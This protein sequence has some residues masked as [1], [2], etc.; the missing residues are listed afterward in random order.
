MRSLSSRTRGASMSGIAGIFHRDGRPASREAILSMSAAIAHRGRDAHGVACD[1]PIAMAH[2]SMRSTPESLAERQPVLRDAPA[3]WLVADARIDNRDE[4]L[5]LLRVRDA[6]AVSDADLI[7][8]AFER[9]GRGCVERIVGDFAFARWD[10]EA[11]ELFCARDAMGVKPFYFFESSGTFAFASEMKALLALPEISREIDPVQVALFVEGTI[12]DRRRTLFRAIQRL[13]AAHEIRIVRRGTSVSRFWRPDTVRELTLSSPGEYAEAFSSIFGEAVRSRMRSAHP[14]GAALSGG[15]D[16]SSIVCTAR[17][18]RLAEGGPPIDTFSLVFPGLPEKELKLID[19]RRYID[20]VIRGGGVTPTFVRGDQLSPAADID[21]ILDK[22]DAPYPAPNLYLHWSMYRAARDV[23]VKV[24]LD[25]F[26]GDSAVSHGFARLNGLLH[27]GDWTTFEREVRA[28]ASRRSVPPSAI[29]SHFGLPYLAALAARGRWFTW[30]RDA[31][32]MTRRFGISPG[33]TI[34]DSGLRP[35]TPA[36]MRAAW[37]TIRGVPRDPESLLAPDLAHALR[38]S[39]YAQSEDGID[40]LRTEREMHAEGIGQPAYQLTLELADQSAAAFGLEA[41]YP[42]FDRRVIDFCLS[43]PDSQK[44]A[45]GWPRHV[46]RRAMEGTLPAEIQ[47][48]SDKGNL[49]PNFHRALRSST[50]ARADV[51]SDSPLGAYIDLAALRRVRERYCGE[52]ETL[53]RSADGHTLFRTMVLDR[54]LSKTATKPTFDAAAE[55]SSSP[56][57]A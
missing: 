17:D 25:G 50:F 54:W 1:G 49:S 37:R 14:V 22:L 19:E 29:L 12:P 16:S 20:S 5:R 13:P 40:A 27:A 15:L 23:G 8:A 30:A 41:R 4:L 28:L 57:A 18:F 38:E 6:G 51:A 46:F 56:A 34:I 3:S 10:A 52:K 2:R 47:W 44:L 9:W 53:A 11:R 42:F 26:D 21:E 31:R 43:L 39:E 48:R 45:D 35:A 55:R 7:A 32:E 33:R 36:F 24:F